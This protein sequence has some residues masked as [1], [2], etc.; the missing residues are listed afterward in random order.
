MA[1]EQ[2]L[3]GLM[4]KSEALAVNRERVRIL[5][6]LE[7]QGSTGDF[8]EMRWEDLIKIIAP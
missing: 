8:F 5:E 1:S 7:K 2:Q 3:A 4:A 6:E